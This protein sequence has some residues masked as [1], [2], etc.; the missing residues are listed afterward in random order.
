MVEL[1]KRGRVSRIPLF[2]VE[3]PAGLHLRVRR[4]N[5]RIPREVSASYADVEVLDMGEK[6]V[7][8]GKE[9]EG[10]CLVRWVDEENASVV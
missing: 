7:G 4:I 10:V 9:D 8:F 5:C 3:S 6:H 1:L 2:R